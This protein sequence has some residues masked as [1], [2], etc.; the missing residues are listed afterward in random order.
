[1]KDLATIRYELNDQQREIITYIWNHYLENNWVWPPTR[2]IH[3]N[4]GGKAGVLTLLNGLPPNT[5]LIDETRLPQRYHL[6]FLGILLTKKAEDL[7]RLIANYLKYALLLANTDANRTHIHSMEAQQ[8]LGLSILD[9]NILGRLLSSFRMDGSV[10]RLEWNLSI[11]DDIEDL[12]E[13]AVGY[14]RM[15]ALRLV[16]KRTADHDVESKDKSFPKLVEAGMTPNIQ[17]PWQVGP[18]ELIEFALER[19][20]KGEDFDRRLAFLIL[21]VG[22]ETLL[23]TFLTLP[24]GVAQFQIKRGD[25]I[26]AAEGNFHELLRGVKNA[27][28]QTASKIDFTHIEHYHSLR[29]ALYHQGSQVA[30]VPMNQLEGYARLA[31]ELL[32]KYLE[33]DLSVNLIQPEPAKKT[34]DD[35]VVD[36]VEVEVSF[37]RFRI[38]RLKSHSIRVLSLSTNIFETPVLP[39][40]RA[41]I[42]ELS[43]P[44][45]F[46]LKTGVE[47]NTRT[48]GKDVID[49]LKPNAWH[50]LVAGQKVRKD[51]VVSMLT[52][53]I[54]EG[55]ADEKNWAVVDFVRN[56]QYDILVFQP[57][58]RAIGN[59]PFNLNCWF[60]ENGEPIKRD[61]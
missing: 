59:S 23:K 46:T 3:Q 42:E 43:L 38:E 17:H 33:V 44:V 57:S 53:R 40:L 1:M 12:P 31:V 45:E 48:L 11:P 54:R 19:M 6:S 15:A 27:N 8:A 26:A 29:N 47:K 35:P 5:W 18:T 36:S 41:V 16:E 37:G 24:D 22:V 50:H 55:N 10:G 9:T 21:D 49:E 61:K 51:T 7:E 52:G 25:R 56:L 13:D 39:F 14:V 2:L 4:F 32:N 60:T 30:A 20:H 28:P 58:G 34:G